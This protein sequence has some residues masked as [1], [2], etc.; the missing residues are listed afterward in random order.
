MQAFKHYR[1]KHEIRWEATVP[2][3]PQMNGAAEHLKKA[4]HGIASAM[5]KESG[6]PMKYWSEPI[7]T[8]NYLRN[9]LSVVGRTIRPYEAR[10]KH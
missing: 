2:E 5:L 9:W 3:N 1:D 7:L 6:L 4:L 10:T 8:S